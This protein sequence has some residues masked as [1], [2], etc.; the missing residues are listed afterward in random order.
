MIT[1]VMKKFA[2]FS[3]LVLTLFSLSAQS[4]V[5]FFSGTFEE[6][7][8]KAK[9]EN[10]PFFISFL[11]SWS[12]PSKN[13][14]SN[15]FTN[16]NLAKYTKE[17]YLA[18]KVDAESVDD[19][20]VILAAQFGVSFFPTTIIFD[21]NGN[22]VHSFMGYQNASDLKS[23]LKKF[24]AKKIAKKPEKKKEEK[25]KETIKTPPKKEVAVTKPPVK[26]TPKTTPKVTPKTTAKLPVTRSRTRSAAPKP[27]TLATVSNNN[28]ASLQT[29]DS[30]SGLYRISTQT[31]ATSG[32]GVQIGVYGD[33]GN[34]LRQVSYIE[35]TYKQKVMVNV[36]SINGKTVFKLIVGPFSSRAQ[37][38]GF[39]KLFQKK[40]K[41]K[42]MILDLKSIK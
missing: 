14:N 5:D 4:S 21:P 37:A 41:R 11:T 16:A 9:A 38:E 22:K 24:E 6:L 40:E 12:V 36:A 27:A 13:M 18:K 31:K 3:L 2:I 33:Y 35:T 19:E 42:V 10:K 30:Q 23:D 15:T 32:I 17:N 28:I 7:K 26:K 1:S 34:V 8:T 39:R 29:I 20:G 25:P